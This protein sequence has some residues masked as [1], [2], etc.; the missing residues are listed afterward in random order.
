MYRLHNLANRGPLKQFRKGSTKHPGYF[1]Q[2]EF[3][4]EVELGEW[5]E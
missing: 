4:L 2:S 3:G 5:E 1:L